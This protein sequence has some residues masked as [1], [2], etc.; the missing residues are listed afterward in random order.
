VEDGKLEFDARGARWVQRH[1]DERVQ[2]MAECF[3]ES[4]MAKRKLQA[5]DDAAK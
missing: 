4:H 3:I 2:K 5:G 1:A